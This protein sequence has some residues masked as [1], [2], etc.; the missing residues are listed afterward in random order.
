MV[1]I[2]VTGAAGL[3]GSALPSVLGDAP[4]FTPTVGLHL[5]EVRIDRGV[6]RE[7][8]AESELEVTAGAGARALVERVGRVHLR[9]EGCARPPLP[10][11]PSSRAGTSA[12]KC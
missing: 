10:K 11:H 3:V 2:A 12:A 1:V 6:E 9:P 7:V 5:P 8:G 4:D